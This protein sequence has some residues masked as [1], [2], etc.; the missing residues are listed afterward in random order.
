MSALCGDGF[1]PYRTAADIVAHV[2]EIVAGGPAIEIERRRNHDRAVT[3]FC[4]PQLGRRFHAELSAALTAWRL[5][6]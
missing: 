5:R 6:V 3:C 4:A 1:R 2:R